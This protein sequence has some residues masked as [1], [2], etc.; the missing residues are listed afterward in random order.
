MEHMK[1]LKARV[2]KGRLVLDEPTDLPEGTE[3]DLVFTEDAFAEE[4]AAME[5]GDRA[6]LLESLD[7]S[8]DQMARGE[9][10]PVSELIERLRKT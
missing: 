3:K 10:R 1:I 8:L 5:P 6:G 7:E 4:L 2:T 9:S